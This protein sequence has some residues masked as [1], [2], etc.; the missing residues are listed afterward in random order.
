[1][2][3]GCQNEEEIFKL[4]NFEDEDKYFMFHYY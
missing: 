4:K 3:S 2:T 1:M